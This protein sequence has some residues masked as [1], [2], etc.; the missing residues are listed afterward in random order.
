MVVL[1]DGD[2][3]GPAQ[4]AHDAPAGLVRQTVVVALPAERDPGDSPRQELRQLV[5]AEA[6]RQGAD[7]GAAVR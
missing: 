4:A 5:F 2:A 3:R 6:L 1:L 7:L